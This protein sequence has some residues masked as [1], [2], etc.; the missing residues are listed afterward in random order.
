MLKIKIHLP[1]VIVLVVAEKR[2]NSG[3]PRAVRWYR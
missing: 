1:G 3:L 2:V